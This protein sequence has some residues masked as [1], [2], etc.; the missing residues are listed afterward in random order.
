MNSFILFWDIDENNVVG[1]SSVFD[2]FPEDNQLAISIRNQDTFM[3]SAEEN[4][5]RKISNGPL[6]HLCK[7]VRHRFL[8]IHFADKLNSLLPTK[9]TVKQ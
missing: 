4:R 2:F 5:Q 1:F 6:T 3:R 8:S 9:S 7:T